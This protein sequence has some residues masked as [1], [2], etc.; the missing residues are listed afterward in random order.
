MDFGGKEELLLLLSKKLV[1][2]AY[3]LV[4]RTSDRVKPVQT[5]AMDLCFGK[6]DIENQHF[7]IRLL[8]QEGLNEKSRESGLGSVNVIIGY[9]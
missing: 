5:F 8:T 3:V 6:D 9:S 2:Q 1:T 7:V 4:F